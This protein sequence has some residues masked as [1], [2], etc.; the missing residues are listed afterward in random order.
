MRRRNILLIVVIAVLIIAT[1]VIGYLYYQNSNTNNYNLNKTFSKDNLS[2]NYPSDFKEIP[3]SFTVS[4]NINDINLVT[5]SSPN[6][7]TTIAVQEVNLKYTPSMIE[8]IKD[9]SKTNIK[10][11]SDA[12]FL[13]DTRLNLKGIPEA[14]ELIFA[15][16]EPTTNEF[17]KGFFLFIGKQGQ[18]AYGIEVYGPNDTFNNTKSLYDKLLPTIKMN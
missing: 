18:T 8:D 6:N 17:R 5:L 4:G 3:T 11:S 12:Q 1:S 9:I 15:I 16:T 7:K 14:Y 13:S 10:Q 2:F